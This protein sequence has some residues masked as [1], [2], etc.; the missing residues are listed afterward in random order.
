MLS[1]ILDTYAIRKYFAA[2]GWFLENNQN[3]FHVSDQ[4]L[5]DL[6]KRCPQSPQHVIRDQRNGTLFRRWNLVLP[7]ELKTF[8]GPNDS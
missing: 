7:D 2:V 8:G 5:N 6:E 1:E 4:Y 3:T